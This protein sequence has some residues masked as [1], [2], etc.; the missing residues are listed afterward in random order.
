M[1]LKQL[2]SSIQEICTTQDFRGEAKIDL[3]QYSTPIRLAAEFLFKIQE[4]IHESVVVDLGCGCGVLSSGISV[5]GAS[6]LYCIDIDQN[7]LDI[8]KSHFDSAGL[9]AEFLKCDVNDLNFKRF[10]DI[11]ITNPPFGTR[12]SGIDWIFVEKGLKLG[13]T[14]YSFHKSSTRKYFLK[15]SKELGINAEVFMSVN[16]ALPKLYKIHQKKSVNVEVDIWRFSQD[17]DS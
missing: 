11:V 5:L 7:C 6:S 17:L 10:A 4:E 15:K 14:V 12:K 9:T 1:K 3:E 16:F 2:E 8:T 13:R